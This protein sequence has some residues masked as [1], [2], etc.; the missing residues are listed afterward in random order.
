MVW[1]MNRLSLRLLV[2]L[3]LIVPATTSAAFDYFASNRLLVRNG[4]QAVLMCNGLYTS[5]RALADV[6]DQELIYLVGERFGGIVG[7][8]EGGDYLINAA[9][10]QVSVGG[11]RA[12]PR[13]SAVF[14]AGIGC[15]VMSP[16]QGPDD[17]DTLPIRQV[18]RPSVDPDTIA[19][20]LGDLI[21]DAPLPDA[22]DAQAL[23]A[24]SDWTFD[25]PIPEEVTTGLMVLYKG[26]VI[27]ERYAPGFDR[28]T[29]TRT[30]STA[31]SIA[32]TLIGILVDD[33]KLKL[34]EPLGIEWLP[35]LKMPEA[36]PRNAITLRHVMH[37]SSG[38]YPVD[39]VNRE[40][41]TGS[42]LS[43]W[44]GA[45]SIEGMR[46]RGLV[47]EPGTY[48]DYENFDTLLAVYAMKQAL[49]GGET[50]LSFPQRAL[51]DKIG[52]R[53][54]LVGT[55]RFGDFVL[56]SQIYT[57]TRDLAR[58]GLLYAQGGIWQGERI[59]S[60]DWITFVRTPSPSTAEQGGFYGGQWWLVSD[61]R[62]D[63]PASAYAT[64]GTRGQFVIVVPSHDLVIVRR[65]LDFSLKGF[66][67]WDLVREVV[68]AVK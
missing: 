64:A 6:F 13:V 61:S 8:V 33:G 52:M 35:A 48:W 10:K 43:Y 27:H 3:L 14:R 34:D 50:Y 40:Y 9:L 54:T 51:F 2:A 24:A 41:T 5:H 17:I 36:D 28:H 20:P 21:Y 32:A 37:M 11:G 47:R 15:V 44:A 19:W 62:K 55:D 7:T 49:G 45:S 53:S 60:E 58:F 26:Q 38:L 67:Y 25:R 66:D 46:D 29:R 31:K 42:S 65:G 23:Q 18:E 59:I 22:I 16:D 30:W 68:K 56:S 63:V 4:L 1:Q 39:R 57:N 12:G